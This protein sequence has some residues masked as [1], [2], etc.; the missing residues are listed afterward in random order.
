MTSMTL[1][2]SAIKQTGLFYTVWMNASTS[3]LDCEHNKNFTY[4][5]EL[6]LN[7]KK[8]NFSGIREHL[9][10]SKIHLTLITLILHEVEPFSQVRNESSF[11]QL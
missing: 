9:C 4:S 10:S 11:V 7:E 3:N 5:F 8:M 2:I 6:E 1:K